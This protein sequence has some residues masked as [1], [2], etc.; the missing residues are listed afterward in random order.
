MT[1][2]R[3]KEVTLQTIQEK[4]GDKVSVQDDVE[5]KFTDWF[6][7]LVAGAVAVRQ[8]QETPVEEEADVPA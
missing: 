7:N 5:R 1:K 2:Q 3:I 8:A 6:H 4:L